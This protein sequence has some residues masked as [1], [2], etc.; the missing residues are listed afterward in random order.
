[1]NA[2]YSW[3]ESFTADFVGLVW[4][5]PLAMTLLGM[6]I[7]FTA[8]TVGI[9]FKALRHGLDVVRGKFDDPNDEGN[10]T[11]FQALCTALS[12]T[13]GLGNIS[14]VAVAVAAGGAGAVFWMWVVG[15]L[16]MATKFMTCSL[17]TMYRE[18]DPSGTYRGGP[19]YYIEIGLGK[20]WKPLAILFA[21]LGMLA[22]LG[23]GNMYQSNQ[24]A[25]ITANF[26]HEIQGGISPE[27]RTGVRYAAGGVLFV[28]AFIVIIGGIKR[29]GNVASK[30]VPTMCVVYILGALY[31]IVVNIDQVPALIAS[32]FTDAFTGEAAQGA[33]FGV[34]VKEV[35]NGGVKRACFSNE[36]G[37][38]SAPMAH[39]AA[40][41][42]EPIREGVVA[43]L[44]PFIDTIVIC[45]MTA[46]VVLITSSHLR[47]S[48]AE[49]VETETIQKEVED[50]SDS[51]KRVM[52]DFVEV[53]I[54]AIGD[55]DAPDR[56]REARKYF[57]EGERLFVCLPA[58]ERNEYL[59]STEKEVRELRN[60]KVQFKVE[61]VRG[62]A[63]ADAY[64]QIIAHIPIPTDP[65]LR[66]KFEKETLPILQPGN[67]VY[68]DVEGISLTAYAFDQVLP[69][70]GLWFLPIAAFF[71]AFSTIVSWSFYGE[72]C[73]QYLFGP[74]AVIP[75]KLAFVCMILVGA[76]ITKLEPVLNFSDAML[77]LMLVPNLIGTVL[78]APRVARASRDYFRRLN[79]GEFDEEV[80]RIAEAKAELKDK[81]RG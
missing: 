66:A 78:L 76:A 64:P 71:F 62:D 7:L 27:A 18:Q 48:I 23:A 5:T 42:D 17:A 32:I 45:T 6:G 52:A 38:G 79:S 24:V 46:L 13:I 50:P 2:F 37:L 36:A 67:E 19:M 74:R 73:T 55:P 69:G 22:S 9:Q 68:L 26:F 20:H 72:T 81:K 29:I 1:M 8:M 12:A 56:T 11:H 77:G 49:I 33:F 25:D 63:D 15:F 47:P 65:D 59:K 10:I 30:V 34:V 54:E 39:A 70:F 35:F 3:F 41:T 53:R 44:G 28:L 16:G 21:T 31:V 61:E 43:A 4:G 60:Q 40:K 75:F 58:E 57:S 80:R 14:G 51:E